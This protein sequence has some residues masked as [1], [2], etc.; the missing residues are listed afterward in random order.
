M[1]EFKFASPT[2]ARASQI[3]LCVSV[4]FESLSVPYVFWGIYSLR[5]QTHFAQPMEQY[6]ACGKPGQRPQC[7]PK[8]WLT[9]GSHVANICKPLY[10]VNLYHTRSTTSRI[11]YRSIF[12]F[13]WPRPSIRFLLSVT[14]SQGEVSSWCQ[15]ESA[16]N[17]VFLGTFRRFWSLLESFVFFGPEVLKTPFFGPEVLKTPRTPKIPCPCRR[18]LGWFPNMLAALQDT[19]RIDIHD[20]NWYDI[21][22][23]TI[24]LILLHRQLL[25]KEPNF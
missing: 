15:T 4:W 14:G 6:G 21:S 17:C 3:L 25:L 13:Y 16:H 11:S 24:V 19:S 12:V 10:H 18:Q 1:A 23:Y 8:V 9:F 20:L 7:F 2:Y 5:S 22:W